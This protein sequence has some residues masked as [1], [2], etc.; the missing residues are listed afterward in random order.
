MSHQ[1]RTLSTAG[2]LREAQIWVV[3][4][5]TCDRY[6]PALT[7]EKAPEKIA[8]NPFTFTHLPPIFSWLELT[9]RKTGVGLP[10]LGHE[11]LGNIKK[12]NSPGLSKWMGAGAVY[13]DG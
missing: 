12:K 5:N 1:Q 3:P 9:I 11:Q 6:L 13:W 10:D 2:G 8:V 4:H 7:S